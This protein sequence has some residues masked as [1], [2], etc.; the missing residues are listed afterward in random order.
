MYK[1]LKGPALINP[2][3]A[4]RWYAALASDLQ[5]SLDDAEPLTWLKHLLDKQGRKSTTRLPWHLT[6]LIVEEYVRMQTRPETMETIPEDATAVSISQPQSPTS[7]PYPIRSRP[8]PHNSFGPSISR[9]LSYEGHVSFEPYMESTRASLEGESRRSGDGNLRAWRQSLPGVVDSP[10]SSLYS[11]NQ[12]VSSNINNR[13]DMSRLTSP[14]RRRPW[15]SED[16]SS[17]ARNSQSEDLS[18]SDDGDPKRRRIRRNPRPPNLAFSPLVKLDNDAVRSRPLSEADDGFDTNIDAPLTVKARPA[19]LSDDGEPTAMIR[20]NSKAQMH[21]ELPASA[22]TPRALPFRKGGRMSLPSTRILEG[23]QNRH[24]HQDEADEEKERN[25]YE[26]KAQYVFLCYLQ[27]L[28]LIIYC[29]LLG[30]AMSRNHRIRQA[31]QRVAA[32]VREYD[33]LQT[34]LI[35]SLGV[36]HKSIPTELLD[37]FSHDPAAVTGATQRWRGWRAV[38]DI[39][40][41]ITRQRETLRIFLSVSQDTLSPPDS[42]F[43]GPIPALSQTLETLEGHREAC[44]TKAGEVAG[45]LTSVKGI[46]ASV[47]TEYNDTL[48]HTSVVYP[49]VRF[50]R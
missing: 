34:N 50:Y 6:A 7:T 26:L 3:S 32:G 12:S 25:N 23:E 27:I 40:N 17:S 13:P 8:S 48:S 9:R 31:L 24:H 10:H 30:D 36:P 35:K 39:H 42:V 20:A 44:V 22:T 28:M 4:V 49:E 33:L 16:G 21:T 43:D 14:I 37:A 19:T 38:E 46:H 29:R 1:S 41:R 5:L 45:I 2:A 18:R 15:G 11:S 47:K